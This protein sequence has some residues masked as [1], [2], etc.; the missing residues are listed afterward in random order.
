MH[1]SK[2]VF[3]KTLIT[4]VFIILPLTLVAEIVLSAK[5]TSISKSQTSSTKQTTNVKVG[6]YF[7]KGDALG[8]FLFGG[9]DFIM[10][11]QQ[12]AGFEITASK[13]GN[14]YKQIFMGEKYGVLTR[15]CSGQKH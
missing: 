1:N 5:Q 2:K 6:K 15:V 4:F 8:Y 10:I 14:V 3:T 12:G 13:D 11:F 9:S 7:N